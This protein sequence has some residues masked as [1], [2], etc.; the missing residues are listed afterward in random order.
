MQTT[1]AVE[2]IKV[3]LPELLDI[4]TPG[5]EVILTRN[6]QPLAK[7]VSDP[8]NEV[9]TSPASYWEIAIKVSLGKWR[10]NRPYEDFLDI[11][12]KQYGFLVLPIL[13]VHTAR[14]IGLLFHHKDPF[15]TRC[16][17]ANLINSVKSGIHCGIG[18]DS[19][20]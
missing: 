9:L 1:M 3:T 7:L 10:L 12:L 8:A 17:I 4:L 18:S 11:G 20:I 13:P 6:Q 2:D 15:H 14:L 5:D 19:I 16:R